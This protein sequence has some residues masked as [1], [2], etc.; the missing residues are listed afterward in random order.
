ME[1]QAAH[2]KV[3]VQIAL[4]VH[5]AMMVQRP[6]L[7]VTMGISLVQVHPLALPALLGNTQKLFLSEVYRRGIGQ[8]ISPL[9]TIVQQANTKTTRGHTTP[10][11]GASLAMEA[12]MPQLVLLNVAVATL[13]NI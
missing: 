4:L 1:T 3:L 2:Q 7:R 13:V 12:N 11:L 6:A 5:T 9:V 8:R 10:F